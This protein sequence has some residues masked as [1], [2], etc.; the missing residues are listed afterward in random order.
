MN[1]KESNKNKKTPV[2]NIRESSVQPP[3]RPPVKKP[4]NPPK[5]EK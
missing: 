3:P 2:R 4:P 5:K 1:K